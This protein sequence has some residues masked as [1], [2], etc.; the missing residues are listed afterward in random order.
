MNFIALLYENFDA[1]LG[2]IYLENR[3][4]LL[5]LFQS[6]VAVLIE[7]YPLAASLTFKHKVISTHRA[8]MAALNVI[9]VK[10]LTLIYSLFTAFFLDLLLTL[11]NLGISI[12][13]LLSVKNDLV[14]SFEDNSYLFGRTGV[15]MLFWDKILWVFD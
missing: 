9:Q 14:L 2:P 12:S 5:F 13:R 6:K 1:A 15:L 8:T 4:N 11:F 10:I 7:R 3:I